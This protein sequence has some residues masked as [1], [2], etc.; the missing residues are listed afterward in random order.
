[1]PPTVSVI[2]P[3]YNHR[4][5]IPATLA[6]VFAQTF[7]DYEVIVVDDGSPDGT[8]DVLEPLA[9]AGRI[10]YVR[11]ANQGQGG[12]RN[13]GLREARGEFVAY[14]DDD[15]LW[16]AD[17]LTWQVDVLRREPATVLVYGEYAQL[18]P[19]G[20][21][22]PGPTRPF[23]SGDVHRAFRR[24]C[25]IMSLGQTLIRTEAL[26]SAG[27]F[28]RTIWGSDDW[29]M[30]IRLARTGPFAHLA[31]TAL[32][33][34]Q[35][36][37][38]A[39]RQVIRHVTNHLKVVRRHAGWRVNDVWA[40]QRAAAPYF[41]TRLIRTAAEARR[42]QDYTTALRAYLYALSFRPGLLLTRSFIAG[43]AGSILRFP[44]RRSK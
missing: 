36:A 19:D 43:F 25:W 21:L 35:H 31:R 24:Q 22:A 28:D 1:M 41:L 37:G 3:T 23:P 42:G 10:R 40:S 4:E 7:G 8:G 15:D 5:Y 34:R 27:G 14:L 18:N 33:Y 12:A 16:P 30:Y 29:D 2:I 26:R 13:R 17:K 32:H 38:N 11:Q 39:S 6:S 44:P 9:R 20:T